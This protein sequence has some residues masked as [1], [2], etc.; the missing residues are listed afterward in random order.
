M[1]RTWA[2]LA[3]LASL[4][5]AAQAP[6]PR[7]TFVALE[8]PVLALTHLEVF[9]GTGGAPIRDATIVIRAGRI[10]VIGTGASIKVPADAKVVD[11][12]G[13]SVSPGFVMLHEH[14]FY[15]VAPGSYGALYESF[16]KLYLAGGATT[17]RTGGS[18]PV[19]TILLQNLGVHTVNFGFGLDDEQIHA[20]NEF[21]RLSS[22]TRGQVGY[23][24][25]LHKLGE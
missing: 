2:L 9:D 23:C 21:F 3:L 12:T 19:C 16:P 15:P 13:H 10:Q 18:I 14:M 20:P 11:L 4:D 24:K 25:L 17:V 8:G 6:A 7:E 5:A 1:R 22:F